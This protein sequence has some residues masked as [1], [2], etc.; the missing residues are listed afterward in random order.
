MF[1]NF[2]NHASSNWNSKQKNAAMQYGE[3]IDIPFPMVSAEMREKDIGV[4]ADKY[5]K[6][7]LD[8]NPNAV[9]CQGEFTL[10]YAV[11]SRLKK[12]GIKCIA[13]CSERVVNEIIQV[14]GTIH[15]ESVFDFI[16]FRE[17]RE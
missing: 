2:S 3:I 12:A 17:Y 10:T 8:K 4:L 14:D 16:D 7:I 6:E 5:V 15:R 11:I 13:A 9:M 1:V